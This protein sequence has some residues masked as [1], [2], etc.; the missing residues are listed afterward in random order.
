MPD[1]NKVS[2]SIRFPDGHSEQWSQEAYDKYSD[3]LYSEYKNA[4]VTRVSTYNPEQTSDVVDS[5]Q[6]N[7]AFPDG[8]S[9]VWNGKD[10][11]KHG[12]RLAKEYPGAAIT[13]TSNMSDRYWRPKLEEAQKALADFDGEHG[14]S[15]RDY[16]AM[17]NVARSSEMSEVPNFNSPAHKWLAEHDAEYRPLKQQR[18][19]LRE[20]V[21]SNPITTRGRK[22]AQEQA[23]SER[24]H[25]LELASQAATGAER[26]D[27]KRAAKLQ[28]D[29]AELFGAPGL[30]DRND[31]NGFAQYMSDYGKGALNTFTDRDFWTRGLSQ[32]ARDIDIY[33]IRKKVEEAE[34]AKGAPLEEGDFD[35]IISPSEKAQLFSFYNL[36]RAQAERANDLSSAYK[37]GT[38]AAESVG[39]MAEFLLST[40]IGNVAGKA[41]S[42]STNGFARWMGQALMSEK[43]LGR[44]VEKGIT[45]PIQM[46]RAAKIGT[47]V[48]RPMVQG[49]W[50]TGTQLSTLSNIAS[51]MN[52]TNDRG[53]L[54]SVGR[55]V[56]LGFADSLVENWSESFGNTIDLGMDAIGKGLGWAGNKALGKTTFG[57]MARYALHSPFA[58]T[59]K[60]A[61]FNG[62]F[63]EMMEE[64]AGN[65]VRLATGL[66]D[67]DEFKQ[68]ASV[69]QQLE[70]AASFAPMSLF[71]LAGN[72]VSAAKY[73]Q[74]YDKLS[75]KVKEILL[76]SN[77]DAKT[78]AAISDLFNKK[79]ATSED[80]AAGLAPYAQ[81]VLN[82][83]SSTAKEDYETVLKFA[84]MAGAN[85]F[86]EAVTDYQ[87][88]QRRGQMRDVITAQ[89]GREF[90]TDNEILDEK[91]GEKVRTESTVRVVTDADGN[92]YYVTAA[93]EEGVL[94]V[95]TVDGRSRTINNDLIASDK[96]SSL[97]DYL[98]ERVDESQKDE[99]SRRM[100]RE[101]QEKL[102]AVQTRI[103]QQPAFDMGT[104]ESPR[105]ATVTEVFPEG[106]NVTYDMNGT[107][108]TSTL[109]W[110]EVGDYI[111]IP[112][113]AKT[114][115]EQAEEEA[116]AEQQAEQRKNKYNQI[117]PGTPITVT[118]PG[119]EGDEQV[120]Y[121]FAKAIYDE[122]ESMVRIYVTD[123]SGKVLTDQKGN[124][125]WFP[126]DM[127]QGLDELAEQSQQPADTPESVE[128][129][130]PET[131]AEAPVAPV[132]RYTDEAGKVNQ[133]AF[134]KNEPEE[135]AKWNDAQN[136]DNGEDSMETLNASVSSLDKQLKELVA[137]RKSE[138]N[139]DEKM[140]V[141]STIAEL[142]Q[143]RAR[144]NG[145]LQGYITERQEAAKAEAEARSAEFEQ[146]LAEKKAAE[147]KEKAKIQD[148]LKED[149]NFV[150]LADNYAQQPKTYGA[151]E[152][153]NV[154]GKKYKGR[155]VVAEVTTPK[156]SHNPLNG[157]A[158]TPG[159]PLGK[160]G[161]TNHYD[162][163][164]R[165][166]EITRQ[167]SD[168]FDE[169]AAQEPV[170][171]TKHGIVVSGNGRTQ[172]HL[173]AA[174]QGTD[175]QYKDYIRQ[176]AYKWGL[177]QEQIDQYENPHLYFELEDDVEYTA[178]LFD[179][180][181]RST[182]KQ[183]GV[184][185]T[186]A[187][188]AQMT[189]DEL[190][191]RL[192]NIF[193]DLGDNIDNLYKNPE[194]VNELLNILQGAGLFNANERTRYVDNY[195]N[196]SGAGEDLV[197]SVL[198][199]TIFSSS[200]EAVRSAME[201]KAIR[202][203]VAFAFPTLVRIR[204]LSGEYS[205]INELTD[206][207]SILAMAKATNK[208]KSE[209]AVADYMLQRDLF[210]GE[211]PVVKATVQLL[212]Q[213]LADKKY[214]SLRRVLDQYINRAED[215]NYGQA[216]LLN[217]GEVETKEQILRE[218][219]AFNKINIDTY[220][221]TESRVST[222]DEIRAA[223]G[224]QG[225]SGDGTDGQR[226]GNPAAVQG[227]GDS[228]E[229][230]GGEDSDP[231]AVA[232]Q[233]AIKRRLQKRVS[234]WKK[235]LGNAFDVATGIEDI[236]RIEDAATRQQILDQINAGQVVEGWFAN[237]KA[238]IYLPNIPD[239]RTLD[240]KVMHEVISHKGIK[241]LFE[242]KGKGEFDKFCQWVWDNLMNDAARDHFI[243]Y[244]GVN[245]SQKAAADE[246]L[247]H[248][249]ENETAVIAQLDD[250]FWSR[251]AEALKKFI[252]DAMGEDVFNT[253][254]G[255]F[256]SLLKEA[257]RSVQ[258]VS[259]IK[260]DEQEGTVLFS[261]KGKKGEKS[262]VGIHNIS[263]RKL[264]SAVKTG[265]LANPS[266]A[267]IDLSFQKH[268]DF[269]EI[270]L[271]AP[272]SLID[273]ETG[274]NA[275]TY[276]G[277][278]WTPTY[279]GVSKQMS[280]KGWD[281]FS[282]DVRPLPYPFDADTRNDWRE[283]LE[284]D[285]MGRSLRWWFLQDTGRN[286]EIIHHS[287]NLSDA[288]RELFKSL[289]GRRQSEILADAELWPKVVDMYRRLGESD[290]VKRAQEI[291]PV[292]EGR[293][294]FTEYMVARN[295]E[296][297]D[298]GIFTHPVF[299][300]VEKL[301]RE[302]RQE[303][304]VAEIATYQAA[305]KFIEDNNL[306]DAFDQ[307]LQD[308]E[309]EYGVKSVLFAGWTRDGDRKYVPNTVENASRLMNKEPEQNSY[310]DGG[311]NATR[312]LLLD[313]MES[314]SEIR[315]NRGLLGAFEE[316]A[317]ET[318]EYKEVTDNWFNVID[319]LAQQQK[320]DDNQFINI[321]IAESRLQEAIQQRD[322]I[323][324]LNKEYRYH[325]DKDGE[326]AKDLKASLKEIKAL[327]A[328]YFETKFNRPVYL[329]EFA[330]AVVPSD[331]RADVRKELEKAGLPI[332]EYDSKVEGSRKEA[333]LKASEADGIRFS[334]RNGYED[335]K[336]AYQGNGTWAAPEAP[337]GK[338]QFRDL[339]AMR[340]AVEEGWDVNLWAI[341]QGV[342]PQPDDYF[343]ANGPRFYSYDDKAG[344]ETQK[345]IS[346]AMKKIQNG[347]DAIIKVY[348]AVPNDIREGSP[349]NGDWVSPSKTYAE[350]H[351]LSRFGAG[352]FRIQE[353]DAPAQFLWWDG[354][355]A[356]EWGFDD[357]EPYAYKNTPN[358][359]KL[360]DEVTYDD[361]GQPI[362]AE[363][364]YDESNPD[365]RFSVTPAVRREMDSIKAAAQADG[366]FMKAPNGKATNLSEEQWLLVRTPNFLR[367]F[368]DWINDPAGASKILDNNGEP[369]VV[370]HGSNWDP[371]DEQPGEAVFE[372]SFRGTGSGDNGFFGR[373]FYFT[374]QDGTYGTGE[375]AKAESR[376][377]GRNI[378]EAFLNIR[379]P[380]MF[381]ETL[382]EFNGKHNVGSE[383]ESVTILNM[384]KNFPEL[385]KD[386]RIDVVDSEG[387]VSG[388]IT[389]AEYAKIFE[390]T[391]NN[392]EFII[393]EGHDE[394]DKNIVELCADPV[395]HEE[396]INGRKI[397]WDDYGFRMPMYKPGKNEDAQLAY[398]HYYLTY[399]Q[400]FWREDHTGVAYNFPSHMF[401]DLFESEE[402]TQALKDKGYDGVL[403]SATGDE[404]VAFQSEQI[405][406]A[407]AGNGEFT[408]SKDI[409]FS[410][411]DFNP[412]HADQTQTKAF[413][414]WFKGSKI[415]NEDGSPMVVYRGA[416]F[417][418]L[419]QEPGMGVIKPQRFFS[420]SED[421]AKRYGL[422][423]R[424]YFLNIQHP[425]DVRNKKDAAV[426][427]E[428]LPKGYQFH[429]GPTGALD[430]AELSA[431]DLDELIESHPE[432]DGMVFDEGGDPDGNGGVTYR[433]VSYMPFNG[434][435]QVKSATSNN[436]E[437]SQTNPDVRFS[438]KRYRDFATAQQAQKLP[439]TEYPADQQIVR[440]SLSNRN[441]TTVSAWLR[442]RKDLTDDQRKVVVDYLDELNNPKL[443]LATA[444][445]FAQ[446]VIR[447]PEDMPKVEQAVAV[448]DRAK[449]D[450]LQY[451]SPME[452]IEAHA[453][454]EIKEKPINPDSVPTLHRAKEYKDY[455]IV[456]YDVD[457]TEESRENMRRIINTHYGKEASP[458]CLLQG[459]GNGKLTAE[460]RR[461]W[462]SYDAYPKQV[463]FRNGKLLAFSANDNNKRVWWDRQD[464]PHEGFPLDMP[465]PNDE[466][467]RTATYTLNPETGK[468]SKP[469]NK[470][471]GNKQ[472]GTYEEWNDLDVLTTRR[473]Y[474]NGRMDGV[475][476]TFWSG[477]EPML[478][479]TCKDGITTG[480]YTTWYAN[481]QVQRDYNYDENGL[482][483][484]EQK[485]YN[486]DGSLA[487]RCNYVRGKKDG[488]EERWNTQGQLIGRTG[489]KDGKR[490]GTQETW[491]DY[492]QPQSYIEYKEGKREGLNKIWHW[493]GVL[494]R[495][496]H[497][498]D[499]IVTGEQKTWYESGNLNKVVHFDSNGAMHGV[500][501]GY[502]DFVGRE[503]L[504]ERWHY[505]HGSKE[506]L[507]E[508]WYDEGK[509]KL[510]EN[511][512]ND[513]KEGLELG[514]FE[515][516]V[517]AH[518]ETFKNGKSNGVKEM[519]DSGGHLWYRHEMVD[520]KEGRFLGTLPQESV[521]GDVRFSVVTDRAE[522]ERLEKEPTT[523]LY[524][525]MELI[526]GELY[527]PMSQKVPNAK[528]ERGKKMQRREGVK[529]GMWQKSDEDPGRAYQK[530][531]GGPWYYD[532][533]KI[534]SKQ[535]D[536]NGVLYNPYLHLSASP[537]NDQFSA[538]SNR[539]NL[540]T[541]A[542][543]VPV[544]EFTSGYKAEK[545]NDSVGPKDWHSG[546]VTAQLGE[547][548]QVVL[549]RWA[550]IGRIVPDSEVA[551]IMAPKLVAKN[552]TVPANVVT[553][554][555]RAALEARG[556][557]FAEPSLDADEGVRLSVVYHGSAADFDRFDHR[558]ISTG[559]GSQAYGFGTYVTDVK[560]TGEMYAGI[561]VQAK[562]RADYVKLI[563][564][565]EKIGDR[566]RDN[567]RRIHHEE[568]LL[569][570]G[571]LPLLN[572]ALTDGE[573]EQME[574]DIRK[575]RGENEQ[576]MARRQEIENQ[577]ETIGKDYPK[578][579]YQIRIP[580]DNGRNY[581]HWTE[582]LT[583]GQLERII[584][585]AKKS[586]AK[587]AS[588][589]AEYLQTRID[590][591]E[592]F[593]TADV[594]VHVMGMLADG[595]MSSK[596]ASKLLSDAGFVGTAVPTGQMAGGDGR[597]T[598]YV[599][600]N[601][602]DLKIEDKVR[603]SI[604]NRLPQ[605]GTLF[606]DNG[607]AVRYEHSYGL[608]EGPQ[609]NSLV[610]RI[611][612]KNGAFSF[613]GKNKIE[614]ASD[615]AF[616]FKQLED[617]SV[618]NAFL[619]FIKDGEP[620]I[621]HVGMGGTKETYVDHTALVAG[622][623]DFEPDEVYLVH[624]H[625]SGSI[626]ASNADI[627]T[628]K[629]MQ[630]QAGKIPVTGI[631]INTVTGRYGIFNDSTVAETDTRQ[632]KISG[633]E[634]A[635]APLEVLSFN[636]NVFSPEFK[637]VMQSPNA[638]QIR[639]PEQVAEYIS[640][641][642]LGEGSKISALVLNNANIIVGNVVL[643]ENELTPKNAGKLSRQL[644]YA[645]VKSSANR[646]ILFGDF[647]YTDKALEKFRQGLD[648]SSANTVGM[649]D[650]VRV[651]GNR[652]LSLR[653][654]T[655][656]D[657]GDGQIERDDRLHAGRFDL[658]AYQQRLDAI[659][660]ASDS[661]A[662]EQR[663]SL[664]EEYLGEVKT[665]DLDAHV[666]ALDDL[667]EWLVSRGLDGA[668]AKQIVETLQ[669]NRFFVGEYVPDIDA[670]YFLG[671]RVPSVDFLRQAFVHERQHQ[672]THKE[673]ERIIPEVLKAFGFEEN[674][675]LARN[676]LYE[677]VNALGGGYEYGTNYGALA[678][679]FLSYAMQLRYTDPEFEK[680]L[681]NYDIS[682]EAI[683]IINREYEKG[684]RSYVYGS[685][686]G[687]GGTLRGIPESD[688][689]ENLEA[690]PKGESGTVQ[691]RP[692]AS[693]DVPRH[694][695][696]TGEGEEGVRD[697]RFSV[698]NRNQEVF[699]SNA[700]KAAEE[701][702]MD[703]ATPEQW[704]KMLEKGGGLKA[705]EDKWI[706]LSD[707]LRAS[708]KKTLS[709]KEIVD[710]INEHRIQIEE[711]NYTE[712]VSSALR[713][714][715]EERIGQGRS[716]EQLQGEVD[717]QLRL[718]G[719]E[720]EDMAQDEI[721]QWLTEQMVEKYGD[722]FTMGYYIED[723]K[724]DYA[725][726]PYNVDEDGYN[727]N[728]S[729]SRIINRVRLGYTTEGLD[730]KREIALTVPTI[731]PWN[732][733][734]DIH[735]GD[736][737]EGRAVAWI[738]FGDTAAKRALTEAEKEQIRQ[739]IGDAKPWRKLDG[740]KFV[741]KHD[742]YIPNDVMHTNT[743][744]VDLG[745][746][747]YRLDN[748]EKAIGV[749]DSLEDAVAFYQNLRIGGESIKAAKV[750][751]ID[752]IQSKRHQEGREKGYLEKGAKEKLAELEAANDKA[753]N[754][755]HNAGIKHFNFIHDIYGDNYVGGGV[756]AEVAAARPLTEEERAEE[757][758]LANE[759]RLAGQRQHEAW[760]ALNKYKE[761]L[762]SG[763]RIP[764]A[765]FEKNWHELA[766]K[767][768]L[769]L[770]AEE[771]YDYVAWTTGEQQAERYTLSN[772]VQSILSRQDGDVKNVDIELSN[773]NYTIELKVDGD[774]HVTSSNESEFSGKNLSDIVGKD[775]AKKLL[776]EDTTI[777]GD[778]LK[779]GGEGMKGFYDDILPR[780]MNKYGK[781]WGVKVEDITLPALEE[782]ARIM[783]AVPVTQEMKE[784]VMQGQVMFS[785][786]AAE[787][788]RS[789][790]I[791]AVV[792][793]ENVRDFYMDLY[794]A[795]PE[796]M[797]KDVVDRAMGNGLNISSAMQDYI[798]QVAAKGEDGTGLLRIAETMLGDYAEGELDEPTARYALWR[799]GRGVNDDDLLDVAHD[800]FMRNH[801]GVGQPQESGVRFSVGDE[802]K[803][804]DAAT[805]A[806]VDEADAAMKAGRK[807]IKDLLT[808]AKAMGLQKEYDK[809][810]VEAVTNLAKQLLKDQ[811]VDA[812]SRREV[813]RLLGIVRTSVGR[814]AKMVKKNADAI[815]EIVIDN[816]LRRE[817]EGL[818]KLT[819]TSGSKTNT[820]GVEVMGSLDV[821]GQKTMKAFKEGLKLDVGKVDDSDDA[822]TL[823][824]MRALLQSRLESK[825]DAVR[826]E[827]EA[828]DAGLALA[829]EYKEGIK[830]LEDEEKSLQDGLK[831][832]SA[833]L[834]DGDLSKT[835]YEE[836][837]RATE[838]SMREN[839]IE[840]VE[841]LRAFRRKMQEVF[842]G[843]S[844][845]KK[846]FMEREK[847]RVENIHHLANSDMQGRT[848]DKDF[849]PDGVGA[850][851]AESPLLRFF[852]APLATF[853]QML[854]LFGEKSINGEGYLYNKFMRGWLESSER[855]YI[856]QRDA[857]A[858]LDAKAS[859]VFGKQMRWSDI[860]DI[861]R[862]MPRVK[863]S[864]YGEGG[865]KEH[866]LTQGQLL[867]IY[868][869]NKM[870]DGRMKLRKMGIDEDAVEA[871]RA[872]MDERFLTLADWLQDEYLVN[873]R[874]KY[875]AI[876][877]RLFG[878]PMA[879]IENYFPLKINKRDL[880]RN[881]DIAAP[882][883]ES[884]PSTTTGSIIKRRRNSKALDLLN[885]DA[886]SVVI[887]HIDQMEQWAAF[888]E[889]N[890]DVNALL[891]YKR[892][893]NQVQN[894]VS[895]YGAGPALWKNFKNVASLAGN[896]YR[897]AGKDD[898]ID[899]KVVNIAKGV[900]AAKIS[901]RVYTALKQF[902]SM[903]AFLADA[904]VA[905]L[906]S[907]LATPWKAWNWAMKELPLF[908]KRWKSRMAGDSRLMDTELD[909]KFFRTKI[910]D[911]MSRL[912]M[913]PNAFV[914][915]L[916][917]AVGAHA[918]YRTKY[919]GYIKDGF[920][921]EQ[922]N[923]KAKQDATV[924]FNETQQSSESAFLST[925][926]LDRT[927][928][929]AALSVYRNS[930]MGFQRQ[931]H[932][933]L[934]N[935]GKMMK[936]GYKE[937]SIA[938]MTKQMV[939]DG[940]TEEQ[941]ARA[942]ER[943]YNRGLW[944]NATR[945]AVFGFLVEF[946]WNLGSSIAY[947]LFGDDDDKKQ[948]MLQ[949]AFVHALVGGTIEGL[950]GGSLMSEALN[951]V[952]KGESLRNYNP[953]LLPIISDIK[954]AS[955]MMSYDPVAGANELVNLA[956]QAGIG[957]N[958][959][960]L[961]DSVVAIVDACGGDME[962]SREAMLLI[963]RVLQ[964]PQSQVDQIYIDE[965]GAS[966]AS[967]RRMSYREM[968]K[969]YARYKVAKGAP[970][971]GWA[972]PE[973]LEEKR[974]KAYLKR[975]KTLT[976]ERKELGKND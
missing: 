512:V 320:V 99:E 129:D 748:L 827:T 8:H 589:I 636:T 103:A 298:Y 906:A 460:S 727:R 962:T 821:Q 616:I 657:S 399:L 424:A 385:V 646:I 170:V 635:L 194:R 923:K 471:K 289:E 760:E 330:A 773:R 903:P 153:I 734:D 10:Y 394:R 17:E 629:K 742:Q 311:V 725:D 692:D 303:G 722:D 503:V 583:D 674:Y 935:I 179:V 189:G 768:M 89:I 313:R 70:M 425:F 290:E 363:K 523:T 46:S 282:D 196:L 884:L 594:V 850:R 634:E 602:K 220:G 277:D 445:W 529:P 918:I 208:G 278:A 656:N 653:E 225:G 146:K 369:A 381:N 546:T 79:W 356:R 699:I 507:H 142:E 104:P 150:A 840:Q 145:I 969:R 12:A 294:R 631:I 684:R 519:F 664:L 772:T 175:Q 300:L 347:E 401:S 658:G 456:V 80:I 112:I 494:A 16:E 63:G 566:I 612:K 765:P 214:S 465:M 946:A 953:S 299:D 831:D 361:N 364:R 604:N 88:E 84:S 948:E 247:A 739:R 544:S 19:A 510:R 965:L 563:R 517:L 451:G 895:V 614:G 610:E 712:N 690:S 240:R 266:M 675:S 65:A 860:Y 890:K 422:W 855:A 833:A 767:R 9:E 448:A 472:N 236:E 108:V 43:A 341:A 151:E 536:T 662:I 756:S 359:R 885:A 174:Q 701:I 758:R 972:Y 165:A 316:N 326:F 549:S 469:Y 913:A 496:A 433:G 857:K 845:A 551:S 875:N 7:I 118:M 687:D 488:L 173:L 909:S 244:P 164:K 252:N 24:E 520:G 44:A 753:V 468:L 941:A 487:Y 267:V 670:A 939:R 297:E 237:D 736:A 331:T 775:N 818:K 181:N 106:V 605:Q 36:A 114:D 688:G 937:E 58:Q 640:A 352:Q 660:S 849:T 730:N 454:I 786:R 819:S 597:G 916:T 679:E 622:L 714:N 854:R 843:S 942:A 572:T 650:V 721:D 431:F 353:F 476:E 738:R 837:V 120:P 286:P 697:I 161:N 541:V 661:D 105:M 254:D 42:A 732:Q 82:S 696:G 744:V 659:D 480:K 558:F 505:E 830:A 611:Y 459:D 713:E 921:K 264:A 628:V 700:A 212:A 305:E 345:A 718:A 770:A 315:K 938:F 750:L 18:D 669:G 693:E 358:N 169:R 457:D 147:K 617:S 249:A 564:E 747:K 771:G 1:N 652:T 864:W 609:R 560:S 123:E 81:Q 259:D 301:Q 668:K 801:A 193:R 878:A 204:N 968:A 464:A 929:A 167:M 195:G 423:T 209:N 110:K 14:Q 59:L 535:S 776:A 87:N 474:K 365:V 64:W 32:I 186:A 881:E 590:D 963:M 288:D 763:R 863:V 226:E 222:D 579:L 380:F 184:V 49:L 811:Y 861:E 426:L 883:Y 907:D 392:K 971:T 506:G 586:K 52:Q 339:D 404:A 135:W 571:I 782:S 154:Q 273:S 229:V 964:V 86:N 479:E 387:N 232:R 723:G 779:I 815:V 596:K 882:D 333:V 888:A 710:Y 227:E 337:F 930:S 218:V 761:E 155:W 414:D 314:L 57:Q 51:M 492:G 162:K 37:A 55:G 139:P 513:V 15:M 599:I 22:Q 945:V 886:F 707:W 956:V 858:E 176:Y 654:G 550:K 806:A 940:L 497:Y 329:N 783:H 402:F 615:V 274:R 47:E 253:E 593:R 905:Y 256:A 663:V 957:V 944:R 97:D 677:A 606:T 769:R 534:D 484:G 790:G 686:Q 642:R 812:L 263:A 293:G 486:A 785:V 737:G 542:C 269:G 475:Q 71:G 752:E 412:I 682:D 344:H 530:K 764:A 178:A 238:V 216:D 470:R 138:A 873:L 623:K 5:D 543:E 241:G 418:P 280:D 961:T 925:L 803:A 501:E 307:W 327:P 250:N 532:L 409:R 720:V 317:S 891:S 751:V 603:F 322:P 740:G 755:R 295:K 77:P 449:V 591:P 20:A 351:G 559:E 312:S 73:K 442:K 340:E 132:S 318:D 702:K 319:A 788:V 258:Q 416:S 817:R 539:P 383:K 93:D 275:G 680:T 370:F 452:L 40:G 580:D 257:T 207:V 183:Q 495:E 83:G 626:G 844:E 221:N 450:P 932:D 973:E 67:K 754:D 511:Y 581:I 522:L 836:F 814:S 11:A 531:E 914:D 143:R 799:G 285:R 199:G 641:H 689:G 149:A 377:Y 172:A 62:F 865:K 538:A 113:T 323:A 90:W 26:R 621:L 338:E 645:A 458:W 974:E 251:I 360:T 955:S 859:A 242:A 126:E 389:L 644:A 200:D 92:S 121:R 959:Q 911:T 231:L 98:Q 716:L 53:E 846:S 869:V 100:Q 388:E 116:Y 537:L 72:V 405:K 124:E 792:G 966:A 908:E 951:M 122:G 876:H 834:K 729:R 724:I 899:S 735:F 156:P 671:E 213:V 373:G 540:V 481:G 477:G 866:E 455:G 719:D 632:G 797:R 141:K 436:G 117:N 27:Y 717:F 306:Q 839:H 334:V 378:T 25:Y 887:E 577:A 224:E 96:T 766:M 728:S 136:Q 332:Y 894:M 245:G 841:S 430:W 502:F 228:S 514:W 936:P 672:R 926:Q 685:R 432:Y 910:Y 639:T 427:R 928:T 582:P 328:K 552:I 666:C 759:V 575:R 443:Q 217:N 823:Y 808:M 130:A 643:N 271:I 709:K 647:A 261:V 482:T 828:E 784:S 952:A 260:N 848:A 393:K 463:A 310:G 395:H 870:A 160:A 357:G 375:Q 441:R 780:F 800:Q 927:V 137:K 382:N 904:N 508:T 348:R 211:T 943:R 61:G 618:E 745:N 223:A 498:H 91:T 66:M 41:L 588:D 826:K 576:L 408:E 386:Y 924:L 202:R 504:A 584:S 879:A 368:G 390:D 119:A 954:R 191:T 813:S 526:D 201:D 248:C 509:P 726:D 525:A 931:V 731:E 789:E 601:E 309:K 94:G 757:Q 595:Q 461:Y 284:D 111:G 548:R 210:S 157:F 573:R 287:V 554:S 711:V 279:P 620:T 600:F 198:F 447:L 276:T 743:R 35:R 793:R 704:I 39:Y 190:V 34:K 182:S 898:L 872:Q 805:E 115:A 889:F 851:L 545:A 335:E 30:Y 31:K 862:K 429:V 235:F 101:L 683:E 791:S 102:A 411:E 630:A 829:I 524:R 255:W 561:A 485:E 847:E 109:S 633:N 637:R 807:E 874:N 608:P 832:A 415:V 420:P 453:D 705:G 638:S 516:G 197:E 673:W 746:G 527:P 131:P 822:N 624:N 163:D 270:S 856:G 625:P 804:A 578:Y 574:E 852:A 107:Q 774:G 835:D 568:T 569:Q 372:D 695:G 85:A 741:N 949:E 166:Q 691:G 413:K 842:S 171:V 499:D 912:G 417:D 2:F 896:S 371:L 38:S 434:G 148:D 336:S 489:Y 403:Q 777:E 444:R 950:A 50:H 74:E 48:A 159:Y 262:L 802:V 28:G 243:N 438:V 69:Q 922:A 838:D 180:F 75:P 13:Q 355:D 733:S 515:N 95:S 272:S 54:N 308:K 553:P 795:L 655:L 570:R 125:V 933:A 281:K 917:V 78:Q 902:L 466:L 219:L 215:A 518:T 325:L 234:K 362:P 376:Y 892:F 798:S 56:W 239:Q 410:I 810:T 778:N 824:G 467:K 342:T 681:K 698:A 419:S 533:K 437:Y 76:R 958:P 60:E 206:A 528:E 893:R 128:E 781:K 384:V 853:D 556:V 976:N 304:A 302:L 585:S 587:Y 868:M 478:R 4:E 649:L 794:R 233:E 168:P 598:N 397:E 483:S 246:F 367:Y 880:N 324:Y 346:A 919:D 491:N 960:T 970:I 920:T 462:R 391:Y 867:Y 871:I 407:T 33:G 706:G 547:G 446:G 400:D 648:E 366:T 440:F 715:I 934:R 787:G 205:I 45:A 947:L 406:S 379:N 555:L 493:N 565:N 562:T 354:N 651:E 762:Y 619:V 816:L 265:G 749:Y 809:K 296:V 877:E 435:T 140:R 421:Y 321:D 694:R 398:T 134:M 428:F 439:G 350:N 703:K 676:R 613:L 192:D 900:T 796:E 268:E 490:H 557:K 127:V 21:Y 915:A 967:A 374:Y 144:L 133:T 627:L 230:S 667:E 3:R 6:F 349:R 23:M 521:Y 29:A 343:S 592:T 665:A 292:K 567:A 500:Q 158:P 396:I 291:L 473:H 975:F 203:A 152:T 283:Y 607:E 708:D 897:P 901:F 187:K 188:V 185:E 68:F 678:N 825:D 820:T 177:S